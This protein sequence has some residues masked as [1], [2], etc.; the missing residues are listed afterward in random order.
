MQGMN[1][2]ADYLVISRE[3]RRTVQPASEA[4]GAKFFEMEPPALNRAM[5]TSP[6]LCSVS[7]SI[8]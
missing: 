4:I 5:S 7:S 1:G 3:A 2:A 6:K 8:V